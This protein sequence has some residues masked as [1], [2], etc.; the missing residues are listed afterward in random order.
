MT[1][2][3]EPGLSLKMFTEVRSRNDLHTHN[4]SHFSMGLEWKVNDWLTAGPHYRHVTT[5]KNG[6]WRVE[7]R[8]YVDV[9]LRHKPKGMSVSNRNRLELRMVE[10]R[11]TFRYRFRL[12]LK[13]P[14]AGRHALEPSCSGEIFY[15]FGAGRVNKTRLMAGLDLRLLASIRIGLT[16]VLDSVKSKAH[17][18]DLSA[19]ALALKYRP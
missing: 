5:L 17:W 4:E 15:D 8:P 6:A 2:P 18:S 16:F 12:M 7:H 19:L 9:T 13:V 11:E 1:G 14:G 3:V 10:G